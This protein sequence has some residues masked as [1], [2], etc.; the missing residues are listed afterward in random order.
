M[1]IEDVLGFDW[2]MLFMKENVH[3]STVVRALR[4]LV[5]ILSESSALERFREGSCNGGWL[6][7]TE[8]LA[9]KSVH[10]VGGKL[11]TIYNQN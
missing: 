4:L 9:S 8:A 7:G 1:L 3:S 2:I 5:T 11:L 10:V 6:K